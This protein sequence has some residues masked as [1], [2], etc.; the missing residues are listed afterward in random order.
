[1]KIHKEI[2]EARENRALL[3]KELSANLLA[4]ISLSINISGIPK[5]STQIKDFFHTVLRQFK[6]YMA[7]HRIIINEQ[8]SRIIND[9]A[10]LMFITTLLDCNQLTVNEIKHLFENFEQKHE[11]GRL[12]D[13]DLYTSA[14]M[15]VSSNQKKLCILCEKYPAVECMR[16]GRHTFIEVRNC[17]DNKIA[18]YLIIQNKKHIASKLSEI[19]LKSI[20]YE[21]SFF[22]KPGLV[23]PISA[24]SHNDMDYFSFLNSS[25]AISQYFTQL[26]WEGFNFNK[27]TYKQALPA[28]RFIGLQMERAMFE[29]TININ[30]QKGIIF[31]IG[32]ALFIAAHIILKDGKFNFEIFKTIVQLINENIVDNELNINNQANTNG[33][34][35]YLK[36]GIGGVRAEV[37]SGFETIEKFA[38]PIF[39]KNNFAE[40]STQT[41]ICSVLQNVLANIIA[42]SLD[43][44]VL[45]RSNKEIHTKLQKLANEVLS[46][47]NNAFREKLYYNLE[48]FCAEKHISPG[49]AA[50][51]LAVSLFI[52]FTENKF[53]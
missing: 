53:K 50:D 44:N 15:P 2:L 3:R 29:A 33:E 38:L 4:T 21:I 46:E 48:K 37:E 26:V 17:I 8:A 24:G 30:T 16:T 27:T 13:V 35:L 1:M 6:W 40:L 51:L 5:V 9:K 7:A 32:Q 18:D 14:G 11:L 41:D 10:G 12:I 20:L 42:N 34:K 43:T 52:Y 22:P 47:P 19:A 23:S 31:L 25:A 28:I 49:G 39:E 45:S 36:Y